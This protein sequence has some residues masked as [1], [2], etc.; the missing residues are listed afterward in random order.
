MARKS[1]GFT[2]GQVRGFKQ[3]E[4]GYVLHWDAKTPGLGL[5]VTAGGARSYVF[6]RRVN[7]ST[8]RTT[9]GDVRVWK[10][11]DARKRARELSVLVDKGSDPRIVAAEERAKAEARR[12][13]SARRDMLV[14]GVWQAYVEANEHKWGARHRDAHVSLAHRGGEKF[15]RG[16]GLT[17][18]APLASLMPLKLSELTSETVE[19]WLKQESKKRPTSTAGAYRLLRAFCTWTQG[20]PQKDKPDYRGI[21]AADACSAREVSDALPTPKPK[22]DKLKRGE[23]AAWF[24]AVRGLQNPVISAYLQCLLLTGARREEMAGLRWKDVSISTRPQDSSLTLRDK[25]EGVREISLSPYVAALIAGLPRKNQWVFNSETSESGH[26]IEPRKLHNAALKTA[27]VAHVSLHGLRR[28]FAT[29]PDYL[30]DMPAGV[31]A[32]IMGHKPSATA[33]K[34]YKVRQIDQ[35]HIWHAK[36]EAWI[37]AEAGVAFTPPAAKGRL[38]VVAS[39]GTV[40]PTAAA[41]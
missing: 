16:K 13:E 15:K 6:E 1:D 12:V 31:I 7:G 14:E 17:K 36:L 8:A 30:D 28:T 18:P 37:L 2:E 24:T 9:I 39:N 20:K 40:Q 41:A 11:D 5:R 25:V 34:H 10:L 35:L 32:Q 27:G 33:E 38:G 26:I 19:A 22:G 21:V 23:L 4:S 29:L 3:P